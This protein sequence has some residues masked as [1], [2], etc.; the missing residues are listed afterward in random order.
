MVI[1]TF[2]AI[3]R[4]SSQI[5][6]RDKTW[7][8]VPFLPS[9]HNQVQRDVETNHGHPNPFR[10]QETINS[11]GTWRQNMVI[12]TFFAI[13]RHSSPMARGDKHGHL[14]RL[15]HPKTINFHGTRRQ[16]MVIRIVLGIKRQSCLMPVGLKNGHLH[17]L[18][19]PETIIFDRT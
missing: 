8:P 15:C 18:C 1:R 5:A 19:H 16:N 7:S 4:Q 10:N 3:Q 11:D 6:R 14:H 13:K 12:R 9:R 17:L 2:L